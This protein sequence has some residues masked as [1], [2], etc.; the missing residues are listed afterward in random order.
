MEILV[1]VLTTVI[2]MSAFIGFLALA[3]TAAAFLVHVVWVIGL[4]VSACL[5]DKDYKA[6]EDEDGGGN[7]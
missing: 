3:I 2:L 1:V 7:D 4:V 5:P 6:H